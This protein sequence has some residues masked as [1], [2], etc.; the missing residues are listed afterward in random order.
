MLENQNIFTTDQLR[1]LGLNDR[2]INVVT[3]LKTHKSIS[4]SGYQD[5]NNV[6]KTTATEE[7]AYLVDLGILNPAMIKGRG[8]YY[9]LK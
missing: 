3:F 8:A 4:N 7:L 2:Q 9:T 6:R 5:L 1:K